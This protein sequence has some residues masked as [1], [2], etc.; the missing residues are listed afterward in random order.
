MKQEIT[1]IQIIKIIIVSLLITYPII[2]QFAPQ[3]L[4]RNPLGNK[5]KVLSE[6]EIKKMS[7]RNAK[8]EIQRRIG[9]NETQVLLYDI[10]TYTKDIMKY[11]MIPIALYISPK[12]YFQYSVSFM[13]YFTSTKIF[14][15]Y[16]K[17]TRPDSS[18]ARSFPSGHT[19][20]A[21]LPASFIHSVFG[22]KIAAPFYIAGTFVG[23]S[24]IYC[25]SHDIIDVLGGVA[26][27]VIST[28]LGIKMK[29]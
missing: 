10:A 8:K 27:G 19:A 26:F 23:W 22:L 12:T 20:S 28:V 3:I 21:F 6:N 25:D 2:R 24:R 7:T 14:K 16:T 5:P 11:G 13:I 4:K 9:K 18:N 1:N 15:T 17:K 29:F